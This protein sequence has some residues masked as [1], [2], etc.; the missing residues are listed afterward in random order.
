MFTKLHHASLI[1]TRLAY[2]ILY[3]DDSTQEHQKPAVTELGEMLPALTS[4]PLGIPTQPPTISP[5]S[6][7]ST[8]SQSQPPASSLR[9][10]DGESDALCNSVAEQREK[11]GD[12]DTLP[13]RS[14]D[15]AQAQVCRHVC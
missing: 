13:S 3:I 8:R 12:A 14:T 10:G 1:P 2:L 11:G 15:S 4:C 7:D 5:A 6:E 9:I